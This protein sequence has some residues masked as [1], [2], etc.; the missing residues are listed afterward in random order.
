MGISLFSSS[1]GSAPDPRLPNPNP[2]NFFIKRI[3]AVGSFTVVQINYPDCT[4]Y[5]GDKIMVY[6]CQ[7]YHLQSKAVID[8]HFLDRGAELS[9]IARFPANSIGW[10]HAIRF[11]RIIL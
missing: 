1:C 11:A 7:P 6:H 3:E 5:D 4:T 9:P 2:K 10:D 8:P